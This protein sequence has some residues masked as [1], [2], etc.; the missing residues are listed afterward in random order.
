[1]L[2]LSSPAR[3]RRCHVKIFGHWPLPIP[4]A[5]QLLNSLVGLEMILVISSSSIFI[6]PACV[7]APG[8]AAS[9]LF[10]S[11]LGYFVSTIRK[12]D[13]TTHPHTQKRDK[14]SLH[15]ID[16]LISMEEGVSGRGSGWVGEEGK[17]ISFTATHK[18]KYTTQ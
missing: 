12:I 7:R 13:D 8:N 6:W 4:S 5:G 14:I 2:Q 18:K 17:L 1:M 3:T 9:F 15:F 10:N 11:P 16:S